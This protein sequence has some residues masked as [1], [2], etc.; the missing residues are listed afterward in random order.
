MYSS[1]KL[2]GRLLYHNF[3]AISAYLYIKRQTVLI[4]APMF[5]RNLS[6][7]HGYI[8]FLT[9]N[10]VISS[11]VPPSMRARLTDVNATADIGS[12]ALLAC[13]ADGF[14]H[15]V[16]TWSRCVIYCH[17][18]ESWVG[19]GI[20]VDSCPFFFFLFSWPFCFKKNEFKIHSHTVRWTL[21]RLPHQKL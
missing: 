9:L 15:P 8:L 19:F 17:S 13:D 18:V 1:Q 5:C 20:G 2:L 16:V 3:C 6:M 4:I 11:A 21:L 12:S 14:P 7:L 10:V